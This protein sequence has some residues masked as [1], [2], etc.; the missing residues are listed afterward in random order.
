MAGM[1][2]LGARQ[3]AQVTGA[4]VETE[5]LLR[6]RTVALE[7]MVATLARRAKAVQAASREGATRAP[8]QLAPL[9]LL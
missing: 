8:E 1:E 4:T 9:E 5:F 7:V 6:C 2:A 3:A